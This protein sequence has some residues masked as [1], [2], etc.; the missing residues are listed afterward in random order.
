MK[1]KQ[2]ELILNPDGSIYHL[3]LLPEDIADTIF[4]VGDPDRVE[5]V[6][7]HFDTIELKKQ[8][9]EFITHTGSIGNKRLTVISTGI[10]TDNID[11]V[12]NELDALANIDF[13][14]RLIKKD[15]K[16][17]TFIRIGTSGGIHKDVDID[18]FVTSIYG[19]GMD[20]LGVFYPSQNEIKVDDLIEQFHS[21]V[22]SRHGLPRAYAAKGDV[23][24]ANRNFQD[25]HQGITLTATGFYGPQGRS[26]RLKNRMEGAFL[27]IE[28][29]YFDDLY[30]TNLEMETAAIYLLADLL[31]HKAMSCNVILANRI[32]G[33]FSTHPK[34]SIN[35]LIEAV[36]SRL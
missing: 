22:S 27:D 13:K 29:F 9:R 10:G 34:E 33:T 26:I 23:S 6:S 4:F 24:L 30:C 35:R 20:G 12:V 36:L 21:E 14:T 31:G 2:S 25:F 16:Q 17:L 19:I 7:R 18:S 28:K 8:K 3:H 5:R 32:K 15:K 11:I 1:L